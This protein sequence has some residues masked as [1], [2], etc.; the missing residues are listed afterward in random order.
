MPNPSDRHTY[1]SPRSFQI[2]SAGADG[3]FGPGTVLPD[4]NA[5]TPQTADQINPAGR[6]DLSS[7]YDMK[8][9]ERTNQ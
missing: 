6:D 2:I 5:W 3:K 4:G 8:M 1:W 9:G 7:F